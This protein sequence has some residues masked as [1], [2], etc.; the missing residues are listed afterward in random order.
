MTKDTKQNNPSIQITIYETTGSTRITGITMIPRKKSNKR[1]NTGSTTDILKAAVV[2]TTTVRQTNGVA[3]MGPMAN[4]DSIEIN[5]VTTE[6]RKMTDTRS[7]VGTNHKHLAM[8][9][10][11]NKTKRSKRHIW[12]G[13]RCRL[14]RKESPS[15]IASCAN[16]PN[17]M[18]RNVLYTRARAQL[19]TPLQWTFN[20]LQQGIKRNIRIGLRKR[21]YVRWPKAWVEKAIAANAERMRQESANQLGP[22]EKEIRSPDPI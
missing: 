4:I 6:V 10:L 11:Y 18:L 19:S 21:K 22:L 17:T 20:K 8:S 13:T 14:H 9:Y 5:D 2:M 16:N 15:Y 7:R 3:S 1:R 12:R